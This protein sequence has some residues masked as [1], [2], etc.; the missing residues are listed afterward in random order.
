MVSVSFTSA[1]LVRATPRQIKGL[2]AKMLKKSVVI[3][4]KPEITPTAN[5][6][7]PVREFISCDD[8]SENLY[9]EYG[10]MDPK[11]FCARQKFPFEITEVAKNDSGLVTYLVTTNE[12]AN[13]VGGVISRRA[14][15]ADRLAICDA[16]LAKKIR[17]DKSV[18]AI[19]DQRSVLSR[20]IR[21]IDATLK[22]LVAEVSSSP[23]VSIKNIFSAIRAKQFDFKTLQYIEK[24]VLHQV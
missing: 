15:D 24:A 20:S 16:E 7:F 9:R 19:L 1:I 3:T 6:D 21:E 23:S 17:Y 18:N 14:L 12:E 13:L 5:Q 22:R 8:L 2:E 10:E 4:E 11:I